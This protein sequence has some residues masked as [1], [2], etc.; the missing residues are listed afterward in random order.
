MGRAARQAILVRHFEQHPVTADRAWEFVYRQLLWVDGSTGLAHLYES[1]KA[2]PGRSAWYDRAVLF[3]DLLC[4]ELGVPRERLKNEIDQLFKTCIPLLIESR[5]GKAKK[6]QEMALAIAEQGTTELPAKLVKQAAAV[7]SQPPGFVA[8]A[9]LVTEFAEM[10]T[11]QLKLQTLKAAAIATELVKRARFYFT[12]DRKRQ[13]IL[14]EGFEDLLQLLIERLTTVPTDR[15]KIRQKVDELPGFAQQDH[16]RERVE[17]PDLAVVV[18]NETKLLAST[19]WSLRQDRQKQLS[20]ELDCYA[21]LRSQR[22]F[23]RYVLITNEYDPGRLI[24]TNALK[25][26]NAGISCMYH[27]NPEFLRAVLSETSKYRDEIRP[28][29]VSGRLRSIGDFL[30][31]LNSEYGVGPVSQPLTADQRR[32]RRLGRLKGDSQ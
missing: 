13:N 5:S 19:K 26:R 18:N 20:D 15:I 4:K 31:D 22:H 27:I 28:L 30:K 1:D 25:R 21:A 14:G 2:Q 16:S 29:V 10:L 12:V 6:A 9:E 11:G 24:N 17:A 8:D 32:L 23:P 3:T 7:A